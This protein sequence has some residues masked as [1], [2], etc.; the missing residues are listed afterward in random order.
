MESRI[1]TLYIIT[2]IAIL[3]FLGM[4]FYWLYGRYV[5][6]LTEYERAL[7]ERIVKC[8]D[9]YNDIRSHS[10]ENRDDS[11]KQKRSEDVL[12]IPQ[13]TLH[14]HYG[15]SVSTTR[16]SRIYTYVF[17]AHELLGLEPGTPLTDEQKDRALKL[18]EVQSVEPVDSAVFD[19]SGARDEN[20]AWTATKNVQ[21]QRKCPFAI[22][23][24]DS[25]LRKA[26]I[27]A[28]VTLTAV[29]SMVWATDARY[30]ISLFTP[31]LALTIPYS[32]LEGLT[33]TVVSP[34]S[35]FDVLPGMW[36]TLIISLVISTL[37]IVCLIFQFSTV[38]KLS[39]LDKMRNDF[40]TTMIH[41][42]K[43]PISTLKMCVSGI[44]NERMMAD[45]D[46]KRELVTETRTALD[47]LSAYFS[48]LRDITFNNVEQIPLNIQSV[49]LHD[50]FDAVAAAAVIPGHKTVILQNEIE[51]DLVIPADRSHLFNVL[52]NL[53]ENAIKYSGA[54]VE[55]RA[56]AAVVNN[57][58]EI[59]VSDTGHGIA[60][61]D[62]PHV[63][64]RFY[65]GQ[66]SAG[67][68]PGMGLGLA[69]VKLLVQAHGGDISVDSTPG[70]GSCFTVTLPQ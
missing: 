15:D 5:F 22:E 38:L 51:P 47:N 50:L 41:E 69:Y 53:V 44:E 35:P 62:L 52:N 20:E 29:D 1:K 65:R 39:R 4:Q 9:E 25:V 28:E 16:T 19:A 8:V 12:T 55:V 48:R 49:N 60:A 61:S 30:G 64:R 11:L 66:A 46:T 42:L 70:R 26:D 23:G 34:I 45:P 2:I 67:D 13:F 56:S 18:V 37:L 58:V 54:Q 57:A 3:A 43:R 27:R 7:S 31:E 10:S 68:Q 21:V 33:V 40:V 24:M 14:Q 59:S 6:S 32:Q 63:F 17:S 36:Q